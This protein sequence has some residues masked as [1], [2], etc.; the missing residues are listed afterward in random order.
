MIERL[1]GRAHGLS[2]LDDQRRARR[3]FRG[4][5]VREPRHVRGEVRIELLRRPAAAGVEDGDAAARAR[6]QRRAAPHD[7]VRDVAPARAVKIAAT[8]VERHAERVAARRGDCAGERVVVL[9]RDA[10]ARRAASTDAT[11]R[12]STFARRARA[13]RAYASTLSAKTQP[14]GAAASPHARQMRTVVDD[15]VR[16]EAER[17]RPPQ[18]VR[19]DHLGD[20]AALARHRD[21]RLAGIRLDAEGRDRAQ[22]TA[23]QRVARPGDRV[24]PALALRHAET[25]GAAWARRRRARCGASSGAAIAAICTAITR[26]DDGSAFFPIS[27]LMAPLAVHLVGY[28]SMIFQLGVLLLLAALA[29]LVRASLGRRPVDGWTVG[30]AANARRPAR[31]GDRGGRPGRGRDPEAARRDD[32]VRGARRPRGRR[33]SSPRR[34]RRAA[35]VRWRHGC[36]AAVGAAVVVTALAALRMD[37]FLDVYRIHAACFALLLGTAVV[38]LIRGRAT[39]LGARLLIVALAALALDYVHVPLL[40]AAGVVFPATYLGLESYATAVLDITL[41]VAIVVA[42]TDVTRVELE[43]TQHRAARGA[44]RSSTRWRIPTRSATC[45]TAPHSSKRSSRRRASAR[46]R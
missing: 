14:S 16:R 37:D 2:G 15:L 10:E 27:E 25:R 12:R 31:A 36:S 9:D 32:R 44:A 28:L 6:L 13:L 21:Q 29:V 41:G 45:R 23:A 18:L 4:E 30:L 5:P 7:V 19:R 1:G 20:E 38:E 24:D 3:Q 11:A 39:G 46:S 42:T 33:R 26:L 22:A 43:R 17:A 8:R 34:A 35:R 40:G